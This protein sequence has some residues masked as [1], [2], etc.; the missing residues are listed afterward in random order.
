MENEVPPPPRPTTIATAKPW[1]ISTNAR[2]TTATRPCVGYELVPVLHC[3][4]SRF[5]LAGGSPQECHNE[6]W[7]CGRA[8]LVRALRTGAP[9]IMWVGEHF[10]IE[11]VG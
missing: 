5:L 2:Y 7:V 1:S 6:L 8:T 11:L 9:T 4:D 10:A 3:N